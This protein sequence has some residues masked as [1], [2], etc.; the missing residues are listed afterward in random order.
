MLTAKSDSGTKLPPIES[1]TYEAVCYTIADLGTEHSDIFQNDSRKIVIIWEIPV[2]RI[3]V[4]RKDNGEML[5]L[6]KVIS[7]RY[8]L[9]LSEKANLRHDLASWRG[10]DFTPA[11]EKAF[12]LKR[13]LSAPCTLSIMHKY[14]A[15]GSPVAVINAVLP[16]KK[17]LTPENP[18][19]LYGIE[20]NGTALPETLPDWVK[21]QIKRSPEYQA[22]LNPVVD[23][24]QPTDDDAVAAEIPDDSPIPF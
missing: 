17:K 8:T 14:K 22:V 16:L 1:G 6:P 4:K 7:K 20:E 19:V 2:L 13:V 18:V 11:E 10:K 3:K 15:D 9:S 12:E 24:P 23:E 5:D 21:E